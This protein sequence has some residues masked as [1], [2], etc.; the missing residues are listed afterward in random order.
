M[1]DGTQEP[2]LPRPSREMVGV[3]AF[4]AEYFSQFRLPLDPAWAWR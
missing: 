3:R 2:R 1:G 4:D